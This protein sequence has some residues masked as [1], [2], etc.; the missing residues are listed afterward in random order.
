MIMTKYIGEN[1]IV[2]TNNADGGVYFEKEYFLWKARD[3]NKS[4]YNLTIRYDEIKDV[5]V[6]QGIKKRVEVTMKDGK[7]HY[8]YLYR[9]GTFVELINAGREANNYIDA[10]RPAQMSDE[11]LDRLTKLS[12]LHKDGVL[13][14]EQFEAQKK[15]IMNKYQ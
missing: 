14:D 7:T 10:T 1:M 9:S 13:T 11:D 3:L 8:F 15:E 6:V 12:Q 2:D 4:Q 5:V